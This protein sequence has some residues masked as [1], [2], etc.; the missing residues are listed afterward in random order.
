MGATN[1]HTGQRLRTSLAP[2][3]RPRS[4]LLAAVASTVASFSTSAIS[5]PATRTRC[6][7][8]KGQ[9]RA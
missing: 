1:D 5:K 4:W 3:K 7:G 8:C 2:R 9:H 6:Q